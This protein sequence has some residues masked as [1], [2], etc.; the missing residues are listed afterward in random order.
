M[1]IFI[2]GF[3]LSITIYIVAT[4][5]DFIDFISKKSLKFNTHLAKSWKISRKP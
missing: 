1:L 4:K 2:V 5:Q 3:F